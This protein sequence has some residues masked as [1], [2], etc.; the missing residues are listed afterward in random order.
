MSLLFFPTMSHRRPPLRPYASVRLQSYESFSEQQSNSWLFSTGADS[1]ASCLLMPAPVVR[2]LFSIF[3][4]RE[5]G[6]T[7]WALPPHSC[8]VRQ[9]VIVPIAKKM[10]VSTE[11]MT[12]RLEK[13]GLIR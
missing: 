8:C 6:T 9:R 7:A 2:L 5:L 10:N 3:A 13:L 11:A 12:L 4:K 1:F